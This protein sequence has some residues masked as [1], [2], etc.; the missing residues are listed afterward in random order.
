MSSLTMTYIYP[1]SQLN[2]QLNSRQVQSSFA[3]KNSYNLALSL[4]GSETWFFIVLQMSFN[5]ACVLH[6]FIFLLH[7]CVLVLSVRQILHKNNSHI[8]N[9]NFLY[10]YY[11]FILYFKLGCCWNKKQKKNE[12]KN[13]NKSSNKK[14]TSL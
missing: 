2:I 11:F 6:I 4:F 3:S 12:N 7:M 5:N 9:N 13:K 1:T 8:S 10:K 14:N